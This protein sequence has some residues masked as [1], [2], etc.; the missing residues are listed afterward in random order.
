[1]QLFKLG[2]IERYLFLMLQR[3]GAITGE[4]DIRPSDEEIRE[5]LQSCLDEIDKVMKEEG[6]KTS[7][8]V[9]DQA[10]AK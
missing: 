10:F 7:R 6:S 4:Y 9:I 1:M 3:V 5:G 8:G 2:S